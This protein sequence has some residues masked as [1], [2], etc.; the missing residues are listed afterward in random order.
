MQALKTVVVMSLAL[1]GCASEQHVLGQPDSGVCFLTTRSAY[2]AW[3]LAEAQRRNLDCAPHMQAIERDNQARAA[4]AWRAVGEMGQ[5]MQRQQQERRD[6][7]L[8]PRSINCTS[9]RTGETVFTNCR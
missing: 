9:N 6:I 8:P 3:A 2:R 4:A 7:P 1:A 5:E